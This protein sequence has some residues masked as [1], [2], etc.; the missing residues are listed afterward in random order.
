MVHR[1]MNDNAH[2]AKHIREAIAVCDHSRDSATSNLLQE[3]LDETERRTW[4][5][6]AVVQGAGNTD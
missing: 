1:L 2:I 4:F 3:I 6:F 5:L